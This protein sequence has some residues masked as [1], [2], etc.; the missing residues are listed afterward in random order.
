M[1]TPSLFT[2][3]FSEFLLFTSPGFLFVFFNHHRTKQAQSPSRK[4][5]R[6]MSKCLRQ[7]K[8]KAAELPPSAIPDSSP[9]R[10]LGVRHRHAGMGTACSR[11]PAPQAVSAP[12]FVSGFSSTGPCSQ[13]SLSQGYL[14]KQQ[15]LSFLYPEDLK[16]TRYVC[17][18]WASNISGCFHIAKDLS[19][20]Y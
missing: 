20:L 4:L 8:K 17:R 7:P 19:S 10:A 5:E 15:L 3:Y 16:K 6:V 13:Q 14:G 9:W 2:L 12:I 18:N 1:V 11:D